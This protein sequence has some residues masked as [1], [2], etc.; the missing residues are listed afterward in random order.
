[1]S[2]RGSIPN[3]NAGRWL[4]LSHGERRVFDRDIRAS[5]RSDQV[6]LRSD[7]ERPTY[8]SENAV[9]LPKSSIS[10]EIQ[11][12]AARRLSQQFFVC[13]WKPPH[14]AGEHHD[15][16]TSSR[17]PKTEARFRDSIPHRVV[18]RNG[19]SEFFL[20]IS[21]PSQGECSTAAAAPSP[22]SQAAAVDAHSMGAS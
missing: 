17:R 6:V 16:T 2:Q 18:Y 10:I 15:I 12:R 19:T 1:M 22:R 4:D 7:A 13:H 20:I 8:A 3:P 9:H 21:V 14:W 5:E 11:N